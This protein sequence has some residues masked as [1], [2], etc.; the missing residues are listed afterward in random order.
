MSSFYFMMIGELY[1]NPD[2]L[3]TGL[4]FTPKIFVYKSIIL[5][6]KIDFP[7]QSNEPWIDY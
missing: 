1:S 6:F 5:N 2:Q 3:F 4:K 7:F